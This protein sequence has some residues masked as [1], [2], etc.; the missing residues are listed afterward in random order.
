MSKQTII[1]PYYSFLISKKIILKFIMKFPIV[2]MSPLKEMKV[3][4]LI[5]I[6]RNLGKHGSELLCF[7]EMGEL[8]S[9]C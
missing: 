1:S 9:P 5:F 6:V 8:K 3:S 4:T 2:E 7:P